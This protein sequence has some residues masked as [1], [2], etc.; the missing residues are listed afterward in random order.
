MKP[1]INKGKQRVWTEAEINQM[2]DVYFE[3][4]RLELEGNKYSKAAMVRELAAKI[5]RT[6]GSIEAKMMNASGV[7]VDAGRPYVN[8]YK[9]LGNAQGLLRDMV[10]QRLHDMGEV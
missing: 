2:L 6:R 8:G 3:M 5:P 9:P 7:L 4:L 10:M 1:I